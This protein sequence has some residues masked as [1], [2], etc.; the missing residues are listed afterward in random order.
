MLTA[1]KAKKKSRKKR[2]KEREK[3]ERRSFFREGKRKKKCVPTR[4]LN[5]AWKSRDG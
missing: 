1:L 5:A 2:R 3:R 4:F